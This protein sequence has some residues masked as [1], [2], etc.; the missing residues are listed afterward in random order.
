MAG[1]DGGAGMSGSRIKLRIEGRGGEGT[2]VRA[3]ALIAVRI[4][5]TGMR[6]TAS[7]IATIAAMD[8]ASRL[9][10]DAI[11]DADHRLRDE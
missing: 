4:G 11:G 8:I 7:I 10:A 6:T 9:G 1:M 2:F 3:R 5:D